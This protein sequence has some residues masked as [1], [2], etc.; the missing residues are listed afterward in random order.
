MKKEIYREPSI[1][2]TESKLLELLCDYTGVCADEEFQQAKQMVKFVMAKAKNF[3]LDKRLIVPNSKTQKKVETKLSN[4]KSD[5]NLLSGIIYTVRKKLRHRGI[6]S[7]DVNSSEYATLKKLTPILNEFCND[8]ELDKRQ[9]Y[10][11]YVTTGLRKINS[12]RGYLTKLIDMSE[13]ISLEYDAKKFIL[14]DKDKR[15]TKIIHDDYVGRVVKKTSIHVD[16][17]ENPIQYINFIKVKELASK[18]KV[19]YQTFIE[20]QFVGL[21]WTGSYPEPNQLV[22]EKS[23]ERL[24]KYLSTKN[25]QVKL[26][27]DNKKVDKKLTNILNR[28]KNGNYNDE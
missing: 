16:Y 14:D 12:F 1:H 18:H 11:E 8:F 17:S 25:N 7:I 3:S 28:I 19:S 24:S 22:N 21:E 23:I 13:S 26:S 10:I 6:K 15:I 5:Y 9:G 2:I 20:A 4:D 27:D